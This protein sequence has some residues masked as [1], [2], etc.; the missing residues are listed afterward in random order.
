MNGEFERISIFFFTEMLQSRPLL[1]GRGELRRIS[2][3]TDCHSTKVQI[4]YR[5]ITSLYV[6]LTHVH[7]STLDYRMQYNS[8]EPPL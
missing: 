2:I 7:F 1:E 4:G 3:S 8:H 6:C 5:P